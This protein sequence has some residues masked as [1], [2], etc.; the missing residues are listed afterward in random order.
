MG[1]ATWTIVLFC[2]LCLCLASC[3]VLLQIMNEHF[4]VFKLLHLSTVDVSVSYDTCVTVLV[5]TFVLYLYVFTLSCNYT[6]CVIN[7][8]LK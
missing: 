1:P 8:S 4:D 7:K 5:D 6:M 2:C 3:S